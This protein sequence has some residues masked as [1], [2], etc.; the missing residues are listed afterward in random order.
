V[1]TAAGERVNLLAQLE[2]VGA[3]TAF[4]TDFTELVYAGGKAQLM[5]GGGV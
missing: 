3:L 2:E 4:H 5:A 1:I